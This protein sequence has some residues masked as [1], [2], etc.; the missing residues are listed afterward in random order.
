MSDLTVAS[1]TDAQ[2]EINKA[3]GLPPE[4]EVPESKPIEGEDIEAREQEA[5]AAEAAEHKPKSSYQ[6][7]I[8]RL[9]RERSEAK[10][11]VEELKARLT[12]LEQ[13]PWTPEELK[14]LEEKANKARSELAAQHQVETPPQPAAKPKEED[15][16]TLG[17]YL[18]ALADW[19]TEQKLEGIR[20]KIAAEEEK[21]TQLAAQE[22]LV[23][24]YQGRVDA[25]RERYDDFDDFAF[26]ENIPIYDGV[27]AII[28]Q[29]PNG[30]DLQYYLAR[31]PKVAR[32]LMAMPVELAM[33]KA[34]AIAAQLGTTESEA[35][36]SAGDEEEPAPVRKAKTAPAP[37]RPVGGSAT[38][39]SVPLDELPY[40]E[41]RKMRDQQEK[42]KY[43]R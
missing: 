17:E 9:V 41:Y 36:S 29:D 35:P 32:D 14:A 20:Q 6:K 23:K 11:E 4:K 5:A 8:D 3:A 21:Q 33:A 1:T 10:Q 34:G 43:R 19:K 26:K 37:I 38:K 30:V 31:N 28:M 40:A 39:S 42:N 27:K 7:R 16:K 12:K 22:A 24:S 18:E 13:H 15:F 2:A 25:A